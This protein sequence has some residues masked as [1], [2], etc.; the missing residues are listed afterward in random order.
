MLPV[1]DR[2][3]EDLLYDRFE[4]PILEGLQQIIRGLQAYGL[5]RIAEVT[6]GCEE[7]DLYIQLFFAKCPYELDAVHLRH[8]DIRDDQ[9]RMQCARQCEGLLSVF[10]LSD[11][12][13]ADTFP[14]GP[15]NDALTDELF[16]IDDEYRYHVTPPFILYT[17][18]GE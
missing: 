12:L 2:L 18:G 17:A 10:G 4:L 13:A 7:N 1:Q 16:V 11:D 14:V 15:L 8:A 9:Q 6:V 3:P 5:L